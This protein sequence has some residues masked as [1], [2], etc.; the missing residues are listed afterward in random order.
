MIATELLTDSPTTGTRTNIKVQ[1][2]PYN[3]NK[4][5]AI[6]KYRNKFEE[7][8]ADNGDI[9]D[10]ESTILIRLQIELKIPEE[11]AREVQ[12]EVR[13]NFAQ[14]KNSYTKLVCEQGYPLRKESQDKLKVLQQA[15]NLK[16][17]TILLITELV[18]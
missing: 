10:I 17:N 15:L 4:E 7:C 9:C 11:K 3:T 5:N 16:N 1:N 13:E 2:E 14:Y 8:L 6:A 18:W 12:N